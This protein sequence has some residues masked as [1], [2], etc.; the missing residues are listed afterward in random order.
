MNKFQKVRRLV[1]IAALLTGV[2]DLGFLP[3]TSVQALPTKIVTSQVYGTGGNSGATYNNEY[4]ELFTHDTFAINMRGPT[5]TFAPTLPTALPTPVTESSPEITCGETILED[6]TLIKDLVCPPGTDYAIVIG[7]S[8]LTLDLGGHVISGHAPGT[9][10]FSIGQEGITIKNGSIEGFNVGVFIIE[11]RQVVMENLTVRNLDISDPDH[12]IFGIQILGSQNVVVKDSLFEFLTVAHKEAVEIYDSFVDVSNIEV[13][14]GGAGVNF[15]FAGDCDPTNS[16]S[17]GTVLNS[18]F[19]DIYIAGILVACSSYAWIEGNVFSAAPA[20]G[21]GIQ[22]DA[23]FMGDVTGLTIKD[24]F[25][26]DTMIGIEF[27]GI[28]D[29]NISNNYVFDNQ[30]WGIAMRQSLGCITPELGWECFY[31]T[32]NV[33]AVNET[34]GNGMD[35]YHYEDSLGNVWERNT[36]ET[37]DGVEIPECPPIVK[38]IVRASD[39]PTNGTSVNFTV[40]FSEP[41]TGVDMTGPN[42]DDFSLTTTGVSGAAV[43]GVSGSGSV[44]TV[45][46]NTGSGSGTIRL[47]VPVTATIIDLAG[48]PVGGLPFTRG[49]IYTIN[50]NV[51]AYIGGNLVGSYALLPGQSTRQNYVGVDSGPVKV[52]SRSG[53]PII[54]AIRSAWAVNGVTTS[55]SQLMGLPLKQLSDTYVFPG[56]N[57]VTLNEQLRIANVDTS[58][59]SVT[60]TIGGIPRGIYPLAAGE[61]VRINY[62]GLDSGPVVVKGTSGVK[63]ISS[64]REAW[65]VNGVT[66][67]FVQLM[68]LPATQLSNKY[69]YAGYNN[70][71]LN[72][73]LRIGNVDPTQSTVVTVTIGGDVQGTYPLGPG[74]AVRVNYPGLDSGP[75]IVEGT[76]GV[77]IISSIR[78]AWAVNGVTTSFSQLMGMP[79]GQLSDKYLFPAYNNVTLN[80]QLRIANVDTVPTTVMVTIG[81]NLKG[82]YPL[83]AGEAVRINY[84]GLDSGPVVVQGTSGVKI[85]SSIREAWALNGVTQSFVQLMGLPAGQLSTTYLFPAYNNV[86]LNEQLRIGMP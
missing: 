23:P 32:A 3:A 15:S 18:K 39:N 71:T 84:P 75:V 35:L 49:E 29:S 78:D 41:V 17:N 42:F 40:T 46:V 70:V 52:I 6:T 48:N 68:G 21:I 43:S 72:E 12:M 33:I 26:H 9:G 79:V 74:A 19:S 66:T 54:S 31:S 62:P 27:R 51:E 65:A 14:G 58:P 55:F 44:Y 34:W 11:T 45:T 86:T 69:V 85:I 81:G 61:A 50:K 5:S 22:G 25:I 37:K 7:G 30:I 24:N 76:A 28:L 57:N 13:R 63:I 53:T 60:V 1:T 67:S 77:N 64:I 56:Y 83:A 47:D 8:N 80:D 36:C 4:G 20:V 82:T 38:S 16:P 10:V 59:T 73:Q 2:L